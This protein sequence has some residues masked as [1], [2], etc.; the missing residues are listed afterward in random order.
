M[1]GKV[2]P[3]TNC[4]SNVLNKAVKHFHTADMCCG[5]L[6]ASL[7]TGQE[8]KHGLQSLSKSHHMSLDWRRKLDYMEE[9]GRQC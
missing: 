8:S 4:F 2:S 6:Y 9:T 5:C 7:L 1:I 3:F